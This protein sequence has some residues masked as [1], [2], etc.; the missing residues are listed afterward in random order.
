[1]EKRVWKKVIAIICIIAMILPISSEVLAKITETAAGTKLQFGITLLHTSKTLDGEK[2]VTFGYATDTGSRRTY[3]IYSGNNDFE[4]TLLCLDKNGTFPQE[5]GSG[6]RT[7]TSLGTATA[8]TLNQ[9]NS[10]ID[11]TKANK[12]LWLV[13]NAIIPE[14]SETLKNQKLSKIFNDLMSSTSTTVNPLTLDDIKS[15]LTEDDLVFA[16]QFTIWQLT[17]NVQIGGM[18]GTTDGNSWNG[19]TGN[20]PWGYNGKKGEYI[21][22]IIN[23]YNEQLSGNLQD[24]TT[25]KTNPSFNDKTVTTTIDGAYAFVGPFNINT[26][27]KYYSV[28]VGFEDAA[29]TELQNVSYLLVDRPS[30]QNATVLAQTKESLEGKDFY[31]R[32]RTNT[33][34]RKVKFKLTTELGISSATGTVWQSENAGDQAILSIERAEEP[35]EEILYEKPFEITITTQYDASLRKYISRIKREGI[36]GT[37]IVWDPANQ[38]DQASESRAPQGPYEATGTNPFNQ[39]TYN[40]RKDPL[41]VQVGDI[42]EYTIVVTNECQENLIVKNITDYLPSSGLEFIPTDES[43]INNENGWEYST[44]T[45]SV[46]TSNTSSRV[47]LPQSSANVR[48]ECRVTEDA[49]G[50]VVTNIAEITQMT[51]ESNRIVTDIDS[52]PDNM[53]LPSTEQEWQN[54]KGNE[55]AEYGNKSDLSDRNYYYKGQEDD[56]DFEKITVPGV[57]DEPYVDL[58]LRKSITTVNGTAQNRQ[59]DPDTSPLRD[60]NDSTTT[61][62]FS[63]VKTPVSVKAGDV[64]VYT[65]RVFNEGEENAY[66]GEIE[67]YIPEGLGFLPQHK[68]NIS[69]GWIAANGSNS[70]KLSEI[71][72]A[73]KN[74]SQSDFLDTVTDYKQTDVIIGRA[75][76]STRKLEDTLLTAYDQSSDN[77]SRGEVQIACVVLDTIEPDTII[78]NISAITEYKNAEGNIITEDIDSDTVQPINPDTYPDNTSIQDDDDFEKLILSENIYDLALKKSISKVETADRT[79]VTLPDNQ[80]RQIEVT[81]VTELV[82]RTQN[83]TAD[84]VY[85]LNKTPVEVSKGD[86]VTYTIRVFNEGLTDGVV[87]EIID[88]VPEGLEFVEYEVNPDGTYKSGSNINYK[89][90]WTKFSESTTTTGWQEG[91]K[92]SYLANTTIPAFDASK[93]NETNKGLSYADVQV[94]F[95]VVGGVETELKNI[96]EIAKDDGDDNDSTPNNKVPEEDDEDYDI[97]ILKQYDLALKKSIS[98]VETADRTQI[99]LPD[100]Q[101]RQIEVTDVTE[102]VNRTQNEIADATY[103][104]NKTPVEVTE[105]DYVTYT[106]RIFN[107]GQTDAVVE[108][109]IDTVPE[110][111][112]FVEYEVN[113]DGSYKSG[114]NI[115]YKYGWTKFSE[116]TGTGWEEG[117]RTSYLSNTTIPAFDSSKVNEENKGLSYADVQVEFKVVTSENIEIRNI[118]EITEDDG[119]DNDSTPNNKDPEEDDE[120]YDIVIPQKFD[121]ALRKFITQIDENE[122]TDRIPEITYDGETFE[123]EHTKEPL[124]VVNG[125]VVVYTIRVYNEGTKDGYAA[126]IKDDLP[127]G[128]TFL[129]EHEINQQYE[130]KMYDSEGN[131]TD[132]ISQAVTIRTDYLSKEKS[133]ARGEDNLIVGFDSETE[134]SDENPDY[135]DVKVAFEVTKENVTEGEKVIINTAEIS[136]DE[137][138][139]GNEVEDIDSEPDNDVPEEDD[140][141]K[142]YIELKYFDLSLLKYVSKVIVTEDGVVKETETGYDGTENPEPVVKVEINRKKLDK[143]EVKYVYSIKITNEGE[144][145]G[146]A[147]EIKDRIPEGLAFFEEDNTEYGWTISEDGIVTT[148]YLKDTLLQPGE[149]AIIQIVLRW[150]NSETNL[151]QKIN[152]AEI[153]DDDNPYDVPDIDS[154]PD[155]NEDGEDDQD[156]AIVVLS[157]DTGATPIYISLI[158]GITA[159][160]TSGFYLIYKY[161][162]KR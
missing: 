158:I 156:E 96:A 134:I 69:N 155:N 51:D 118:A 83:E 104:L 60:N 22:E 43:D 63:D 91:I 6:T 75:T 1:M 131:E 48:I 160:L 117:I 45:R 67:D 2:S 150:E 146:Y 109:I 98:K 94:E 82:N 161:V 125:Q 107:E 153:S 26:A 133:E 79:Q 28:D 66:V 14:D 147:T 33:T 19:L 35:G 25:P 15:V 95:K 76:I 148:D 20:D 65:I 111:L 137:D 136:K 86:Y 132:D 29:G 39:Y 129:P 114:S 8:S 7:Y 157:I 17:N 81:D 120:D 49:V 18:Q 154:T 162:V 126:E 149:S 73:T 36:Y 77:L 78:K 92:T 88:T 124:I 37:Q 12:I 87:E 127:E 102:L 84:A 112:E 5:N 106:I 54:Y 103:N 121:L 89:Y 139:N 16:L 80:K 115:N 70:I 13:R 105:G 32:I 23:Y 4:T 113:E 62:N 27:T 57:V 50:K 47:L 9:A 44:E 85:N 108:E 55:T 46:W 110:G 56:D 30:N 74:L 142:E 122:I 101:K 68:L 97:V 61:S 72:N 59:R 31:V 99:T 128:I 52:S 140:I 41:E 21:I 143:T 58:A 119:D 64:V 144:I 116:T 38:A 24:D 40:H 141:D 145:E 100:D 123:Y 71:Q 42:I 151:G 11:Q 135:R 152:V 90:G 3:R 159:I 130:W 93:V 34:A 53:Q 138:E 10:N